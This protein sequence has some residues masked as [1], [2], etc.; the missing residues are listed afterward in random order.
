MAQTK[1]AAIQALRVMIA[2]TVTYAISQ[3]LNLQQGYW[4]V[5][6]VLIVMQASVGATAGMAVDRLV[7]TVAGAVLGGL[8]VLVTPH[9]PVAIGVALICV[10]GFA[11]FVSARAPRLRN[12]GLTA[13]I[14][15]L[16][17]SQSVPVEIFVIDR[18]AEITLGGV[19]GVLSSLFILPTRSRTVVLDRFAS[20]L[21]VMAQI[22]RTLAAAAEKGEPVSAVEANIGLRQS[23][24]AAE[25]LLIDAQRERALWLARQGISD[26]IPRSLW[27]IRNDMTYVSHLVETPFPSVVVDALG[28]QVASVLRAQAG[29][30]EACGKVLRAGGQIDSELLSNA[31]NSLQEAFDAFQHS[32]AAQSIGFS[33][34]GRLFGVD[35][36]LRRMRQNFL[37]LA[38]R[39]QESHAR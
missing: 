29:F 7:A 37:D 22:L 27:R 3:L 31:D 14:V 26:A 36:T 8:A 20:A 1:R 6:T 30:A 38:D 34:T 18:I 15:M 28:P 39:I 9:Q 13:A 23:L 12:A 4:A 16:T 10:V 21:E 25:A 33:D 17:H 5:F 35:F 2:C 19:I 11:S 32:D 24:I